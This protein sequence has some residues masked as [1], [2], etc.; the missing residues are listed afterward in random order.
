MA[1]TATTVDEKIVNAVE[2]AP[3]DTMVD[4]AAW[5]EDNTDVVVDMDTLKVAQRL[6]PVYIKVPEV[7]AKIAERKAENAEKR[8]AAQVASQEKAIERL[9]KLDPKVLA[10]KL[11]A[12]GLQVTEAE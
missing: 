4:F 3:T 7:A 12:L 2:K 9:A 10:A 1:R 6:Y 5:I 11:K 8:E